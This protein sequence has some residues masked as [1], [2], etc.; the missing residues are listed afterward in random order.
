MPPGG[1]PA[2]TRSSGCGAS[3]RVAPPFDQSSVS[4]YADADYTSC[5]SSVDPPLRWDQPAGC[6]LALHTRLNMA[7][8]WCTDGNLHGVEVQCA[9]HHHISSRSGMPGRSQ[10]APSLGADARHEEC[11]VGSVSVISGLSVRSHQSGLHSFG[12]RPALRWP[13]SLQCGVIGTRHLTFCGLRRARV[14][15]RASPRAEPGC[16]LWPRRGEIRAPCR[17][18]HPRQPS[19]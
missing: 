6:S 11:R 18:D 8:G 10:C 7:R 5:G 3:G 19:V 16:E 17:W 13:A 9:G 2:T 14:R 12:G 15:V 1:S 4:S